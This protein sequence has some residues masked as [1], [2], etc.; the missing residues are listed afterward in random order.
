MVSAVTRFSI[1]TVNYC[2]KLN[3]FL[4]NSYSFSPL[5]H[6]GKIQSCYQDFTELVLSIVT[7]CEVTET[8]DIMEDYR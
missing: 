3:A 2:G 5:F 7:K 6:I 4:Y 1:P 8:N